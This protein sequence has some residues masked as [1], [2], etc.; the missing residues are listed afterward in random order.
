MEGCAPRPLTSEIHLCTQTPLSGSAPGACKS[1]CSL[2]QSSI[3][4][5]AIRWICNIAHLNMDYIQILNWYNII[6]K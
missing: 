1:S 3:V 6:A 2:V 4:L 5:I